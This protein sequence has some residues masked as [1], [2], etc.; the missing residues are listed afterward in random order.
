MGSVVRRSFSALRT[1]DF[2][3]VPAISVLETSEGLGWT[4]V[5]MS[6]QSEAPYRASFQPQSSILISLV[7]SGRATATVTIDKKAASIQ[8]AP[9]TI[10]IIPDG[11]GFEVD[12]QSRIG[13]THLYLPREIL[14]EVSE[15]ITQDSPTRIE[16]MARIAIFDPILEQLCRAVRDA[17]DEDPSS[18]RLYVEYMARAIAAHLITA[19]SNVA[20]QNSALS[21]NRRLSAR[22]LPRVRE[23]VESKLG[24]RLTTSDIA[25]ETGMGPDHFGRLFKQATGTTLYQFVIRCRVDR[26]RR[27]LV[28]TSMPIL[29]IARECGF[30]DQVHLTR[31]F[32][33]FVGTSPA[34]FR[35][36]NRR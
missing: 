12:L 13:T 15:D 30:A 25:A 6:V 26:A 9:G 35:K 17:L 23:M 8:G 32:G 31:S 36:E 20:T 7:N 22:L 27:L 4:A 28:D 18:S 21:S 5:H 11:V 3:R 33:R 10:T 29:Q 2:A 16:L 34:A 1:H 24:D 19:H 14:D